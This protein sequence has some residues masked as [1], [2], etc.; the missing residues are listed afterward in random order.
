MHTA[1]MAL[2][3]CGANDIVA[4]WRKNP[5]EAWRRLQ[6]RCDPTTGGRKRNLLRTII[7]S[8]WSLLELQARIERWESYVSRYENKLKDKLDDEIKLAGLEALVPELEKNLIL[9]S[10]RLRTFD[11]VRLEVVTYVEAKFGLRIRDSKPSETDPMDVDAVNSLSSGKGRGSSSP[12]DGCLKCGGAHG[13]R[14]CNAHKS[15][16][17]QSYGKGKQCKSWSKIE[18]KG[19][20]KITRENPKGNPKEPKV[21]TKVPKARTKGKTSKAGLSGLENSK[22]ERSSDIQKSAQ[23]CSTD[24]SWNDGWNFDEWHDGWSSDEWNDEWSS[25]GWHEGWEQTYDTSASSFS[26]GGL[27]ASSSPKRF[28]WVNMNLDTG[29]SEH[30]PIEFWS[31]MSGRW[32]NLSDFQW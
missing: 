31:R 7:S 15:T 4:N 11:D 24:T 21:R 6:I 27:D 28:E 26:L 19:R 29:P 17:K 32:K 30:I 8:G 14:D 10:N 16:G 13:Q 23:V 20:V 9:N 2:A 22:W 5:L 12:P 18:D 25:V 3:G 1:L